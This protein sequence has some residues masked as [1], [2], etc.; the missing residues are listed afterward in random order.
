[1]LLWLWTLGKNYG[2][3]EK[4][5]AFFFFRQAVWFAHLFIF[6]FPLL[7]CLSGFSLSSNNQCLPTG[8]IQFIAFSMGSCNHGTSISSKMLF[9]LITALWKFKTLHPGIPPSTSINFHIRAAKYPRTVWSSHKCWLPKIS[10]NQSV[11]QSKQSLLLSGV[12]ERPAQEAMAV[13]QS[14]KHEVEKNICW[15]SELQNKAN[16]SIWRVGE[17]G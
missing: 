1:M 11:D 12:R 10:P 9:D 17:V 5:Y 13:S 8:V 2:H 6:C 7:P 14:E 3:M 16:L 15:D 4:D